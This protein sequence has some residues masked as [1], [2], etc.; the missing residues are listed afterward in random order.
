MHRQEIVFVRNEG[1]RGITTLALASVE[2]KRHLS[3]EEA[4]AA[5][6]SSVS[7]WVSHDLPYTAARRSVHSVRYLGSITPVYARFEDC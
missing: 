3:Q 7:D 6:E 5:V 4:L 2:S 1:L